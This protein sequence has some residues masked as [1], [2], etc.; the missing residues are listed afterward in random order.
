MVEKHHQ[1][2]K[3][4]A[5]APCRIQLPVAAV[6]VLRGIHEGSSVWLMK[7]TVRE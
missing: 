2:K 3:G 4:V 7:E 1:A 5:D 6:L